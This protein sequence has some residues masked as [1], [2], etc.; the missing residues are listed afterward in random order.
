MEK[1]SQTKEKE[2]I[3]TIVRGAVVSVI[4]TTK[5]LQPNIQKAPKNWKEK[6]FNARLG[7]GTQI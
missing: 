6:Q 5:D 2:I 4:Q 3:D 7:E 1:D